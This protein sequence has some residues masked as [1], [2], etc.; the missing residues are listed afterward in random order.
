[1]ICDDEFDYLI[2]D[3]VMVSESETFNYA[4]KDANVHGLDCL[5][6][7]EIGLES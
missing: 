1:M 4:G 3:F 5:E 2:E 6:F 7:W